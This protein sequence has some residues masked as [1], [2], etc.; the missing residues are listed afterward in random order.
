MDW[1]HSIL[2]KKE[3]KKMKLGICDD[4][5]V[6]H[7]QVKEYI[8]DIDFGIPLEVTDFYN[9]EALI[10]S[11][12]QIDI[13]LLDICM[14]GLDGIEVGRKLKGNVNI[15][16]IIM[17]TSMLERSPEAFEIET[18]RFITKPIDRKKL[19]NVIREA[20]DTFV[21]C[22]QIEVYLDNQKYRFQQRQIRYISK[23][24]SRTEVIIGRASFQSGMTLAEWEKVLDARMFLQV[25]KSHIV[26]LSEIERIEDKIMLKNGEILPVARRRKSEL[27]NR[28]IQYDFEVSING[29]YICKFCVYSQYYRGNISF[30]KRKGMELEIYIPV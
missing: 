28:F 8:N 19:V 9:G 7:H 15:G 11:A 6:V 30:Q 5:A 3:R 22:T 2:D 1:P 26:N 23:L 4:E 10:E 12:S 25:H 24:T 27:L 21:G 18:Y 16:K 14:P 17:L 20:I 13:L 29:I